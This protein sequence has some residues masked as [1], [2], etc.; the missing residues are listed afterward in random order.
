[1]AL[2]N[3]CGSSVSPRFIVIVFPIRSRSLC[4]MSNC[5]KAVVV[6]WIV[7]ALVTL[8]SVLTKTTTPLTFSNNETTVT[9][10][11]CFDRDDMN[12]LA[13]AIYQLLTL[14][15]LP[16]LVMVVCYAFVIRD[17]WKSTKS[18]QTLTNSR[19][20]SLQRIRRTSDSLGITS[21][22]RTPRGS[23]CKEDVQRSRKQV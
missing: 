14:F 12:M 23:T 22:N 9:V 11:Y 19:R 21:P 6:V 20:K 3:P 4:T 16:A 5:R 2:P 18:I 13:Y 15:A 17:L 8:P 10:H 1:M 7:S